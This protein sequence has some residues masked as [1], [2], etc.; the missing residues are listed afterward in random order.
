MWRQYSQMEAQPSFSPRPPTISVAEWNDQAATFCT[1]FGDCSSLV[2]EFRD[3]ILVSNP[4]DVYETAVLIKQFLESC[5][6]YFSLLESFWT[7]GYFAPTTEITADI[8]DLQRYFLHFKAKKQCWNLPKL[9]WRWMQYRSELL[10]GSRIR[11]AVRVLWLLSL[12]KHDISVALDR[13]GE[14]IE[15]L[16]SKLNPEVSQVKLHILSRKLPDK[17]K[18]LL[19]FSLQPSFGWQMFLILVGEFTAVCANFPGPIPSF[20]EWKVDFWTY[21]AI[22]SGDSQCPICG[23]T[24][25]PVYSEEENTEPALR[26]QE[27]GHVCGMRCLKHWADNDGLSCPLCRKLPVALPI[28]LSHS[29]IPV[30]RRMCKVHDEIRKAS[31]AIDRYILNEPSNF[32]NELFVNMIHRGVINLRT[33]AIGWCD[34]SI[35]NRE[36]AWL[37]RVQRGL[38]KEE[39]VASDDVRVR[40]LAVDKPLTEDRHR[41]TYLEDGV[42][43]HLTEMGYRMES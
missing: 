11:A 39:A 21:E 33:N 26:L 12:N 2:L 23:A 4:Y 19:D 3:K 27:C 17:Y 13:Y 8:R 16:T 42:L 41:M 29:A 1:S 22:K 10:R 36:Q 38:P 32:D 34:L 14:S 43:T 31:I 35:V 6:Q 5:D 7:R 37:D 28:P 24:Y 25:G 9:P 40:W 15:G 18:W 20:H 30:Y